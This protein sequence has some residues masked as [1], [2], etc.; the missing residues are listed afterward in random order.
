MPS[1]VR[2]EVRLTTDQRICVVTVVKKCILTCSGAGS[3]LI[4][5]L[6]KSKIPLVLTTKLTHSRSLLFRQQ[7]GVNSVI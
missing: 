6:Y 5:L 2:T 4:F 1:C 7:D 3:L